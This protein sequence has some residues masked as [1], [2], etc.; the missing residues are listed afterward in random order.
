[1][2]FYFGCSLGFFVGSIVGWWFISRRK[3]SWMYAKGLAQL[4]VENICI[5]MFW[6]LKKIGKIGLNNVYDTIK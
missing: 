4:G 1:V 6:S 2:V 5:V 3:R